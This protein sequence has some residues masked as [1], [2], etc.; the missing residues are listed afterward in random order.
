MH[1]LL[2]RH[3]QRHGEKNAKDREN[4]ERYSRTETEITK[5]KAVTRRIRQRRMFYNSLHRRYRDKRPRD[6][7][8]GS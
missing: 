8:A 4:K 7:V 2:Q 5:G 3:G 1:R 6:T